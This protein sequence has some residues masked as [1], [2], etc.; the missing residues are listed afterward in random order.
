MRFRAGGV[1]L[2]AELTD[3]RQ[4][5]IVVVLRDVIALELD[6]PHA[7]HVDVVLRQVEDI[8]RALRRRFLPRQLDHAVVVE[9]HDFDPRQFLRRNV[10]RP[11]T[12][13]SAT[14]AASTFAPLSRRLGRSWSLGKSRRRHAGG[15]RRGQEIPSIH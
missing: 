6:V 9:G 10:G 14:S 13:A 11:A 1:E 3:V 5:R 7:V 15:R 8:E 4:V 12:S 2:G